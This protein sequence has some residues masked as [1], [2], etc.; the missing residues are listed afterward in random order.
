MNHLHQNKNV[1]LEFIYFFVLF[2]KMFK[3]STYKV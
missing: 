1:L 3:A 2:R